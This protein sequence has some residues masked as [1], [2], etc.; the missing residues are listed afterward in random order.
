LE[1]V[2]ETF[3]FLTS[4][5]PA[6]S[7]LALPFGLKGRSEERSVRAMYL[8]HRSGDPIVT[9]ASEEASPLASELLEPVLGA[10]RDFVATGDQSGRRMSQTSQRFGE[11]GV[12][13]VRGQY[14]SA[15]AVIH[16]RGDGLF[17]R[18]LLRFIQDFEDRNRDRLETWESATRLV[19][20][21][22]EAMVSLMDGRSSGGLAASDPVPAAN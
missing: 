16:G 21:A 6:A 14:V 22:S 8:F 7:M 3:K 20:E 17:R 15:C 1:G 4:L 19:G 9:M 12:I 10:V 5:V 2:V 11:E 18:D 13:G